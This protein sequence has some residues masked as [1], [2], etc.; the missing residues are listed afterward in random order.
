M[1]DYAQLEV[2]LHALIHAR[3]VD[4]QKLRIWVAGCASGEEAYSIAMLIQDHL[5]KHAI[6]DLDVRVMAS[7]VKQDCL[8]I[9]KLGLYSKW[10]VRGA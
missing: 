6:Q 8:K 9:A 3:T 4:Q 5:E 7:D 1:K 10:V 2:V